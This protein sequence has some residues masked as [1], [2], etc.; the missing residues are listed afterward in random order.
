MSSSTALDNIF[1]MHFRP[2]CF[3]ALHYLGNA[4][5]AEDCVQECFVGLWSRME[6]RDVP[7][8]VRGYLYASVRNRCIDLLRK[9]GRNPVPTDLESV[10]SEEEAQERSSL[11]A[12][13]WDAVSRL[14]EK[15]RRI[16]LMAKRDNMSYADIAEELGLSENTV[17]NQ[18]SRALASLR[19]EKK[20][21][22]FV[23]F[24]F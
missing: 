9:A 13:L 24:F 10:I 12:Q 5:E 14:P 22:D 23:I 4:A 15:R 11:E 16:L 19:A 8:N 7:E 21:I 3:Y 6:S 1:R 17:R 20:H 2:L 18:I